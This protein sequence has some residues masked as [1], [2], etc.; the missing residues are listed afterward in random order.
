MNQAWWNLTEI[1]VPAQRL[2]SDSTQTE[3]DMQNFND[4]NNTYLNQNYE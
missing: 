4:S 1:I 2:P 3:N